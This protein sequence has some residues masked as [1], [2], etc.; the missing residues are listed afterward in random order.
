[1]SVVSSFNHAAHS[2]DTTAD[3]QAIVAEALLARIGYLSPRSILDIGCGTGLLTALALKRWPDAA[4]TAV[5]AAPA[6]LDVARAKLPSVRF[7]QGD[8][9]HLPLTEKFDLVLSSMV[10][11][12]LK[13][14]VLAHWKEFVA[15][16]GGLHVA[17]PV[18]GSLR[19]WADHCKRHGTEDGLWPFP[20]RKAFAAVE[21]VS[22]AISYGSAHDFLLAMKQT[23][24][25]TGD[26]AKPVMAAGTL[27]RLL[28]AAPKPFSATFQIAYL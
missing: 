21:V 11:H 22:H 2:Y 8:A 5:D 18:D 25:A 17:F 9:A 10:L 6:M 27:R 13:P 24:A 19:E 26:A 12:W 28:R 23:G 3:I 15:A 7:L 16:Q 14:D 20:A 4:I 1:M